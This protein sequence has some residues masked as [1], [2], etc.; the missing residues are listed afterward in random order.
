GVGARPGA[1]PEPELT[2]T[3]VGGYVI[4]DQLGAGGMGAVYRAKHLDTN[5]VVALTSLH[6]HHLS[7]PVAGEGFGGEGGRGWRVGQRNIGGVGEVVGPA[8]GRFCIG[9]ERVEGDPRWAIMTRPLPRERRTLIT[10]QRL[11]G[12]EHAH[13]MGLVHRD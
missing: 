13:A 9:L 12:L 1:E 4:E 11:R 10:A 5:R 8:H 7:E 2:G 6:A 3:V